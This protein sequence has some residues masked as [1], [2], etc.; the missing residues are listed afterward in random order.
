MSINILRPPYIK[1]KN[2]T[3]NPVVKYGIPDYAD[4]SLNPNVVGTPKWQTY[5]EEQLFYI[6][7]GYQTGGYFLP[8]RYYYYL[9]F[10][11]MSTITGIISPDMVDLHLELAYLIEWAK[12]NNKNVIVAKKRRA[13]I[14]EFT[15]K[16]VIDYGW[17][18]K[19]GYKAGIAAGKSTYA[20]ELMN[21]WEVSEALLPP[22]FSVK[23]LKKNSSE[24][25]AGYRAENSLGDSIEQGTKNQI[26][27]E[28]THQ[29]AELFKGLYL[30]DVIAEECG[31]FEKLEE[32]YSAT[33]ACL[34]DGSQQIG[35]MF[36]YGTGGNMDKGSKGFNEIWHNADKYD[37]VKFLIPAT[38]FHK[39]F[40]GGATQYGVINEKVPNL[41]KEF[42]P[43][44][45]I[46]VEDHEAAK[47]GILE[48][49]DREKRSG[50]IEKYNAH[51]QD[52]PFTEDEIFK[53]TIVNAFDED[54]L[55]EQQTQIL[56]QNKKY[57]RC[58]LDYVK[59]QTGEIK[60]PLQVIPRVDNTT[61]EDGAVILIHEDH[62]QKITTHDNMYVAGVDSYDQH[63]SKTS[64]SKGAMCV[65]IRRNTIKDS[66]QMA[67]IA[68]ICCRPPRKE[69][70][71]EMCL[72]L[73]IFYDLRESVLMDVRTPAIM[74]FFRERGCEKYLAFRPRKFEKEDSEQVNE[75]GISL[76][77]HSRPLMVG[78]MQSSILDYGKYIWFPELIKQ[79][80]NYDE[81]SIG[82]DND[83]GDAYGIA[84]MQDSASELRTR[85]KKETTNDKYS[86]DT[87]EQDSE[88]N[89]IPTTTHLKKNIVNDLF[90]IEKDLGGNRFGK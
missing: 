32:F 57:V 61:P 83:L 89:M 3:F 70:F 19:L 30:N 40:Y 13:G 82:S 15:H 71:Y 6:H 78:L 47:V 7:N 74:E 67:P 68:T 33:K 62:L 85:D 69:I 28:T 50:D 77:N 29:D 90:N 11:S 58:Q 34:K 27:V 87:W 63:L 41:L 84:L 81:V 48:E 8:G 86:L 9:N 79:L 65:L 25:I 73:A 52:Y 72:K 10:N 53:R 5:W 35:T 75:Y 37:F 24:I 14:S 42:K 39:P 43:Y 23:K 55:N 21:K 66:L 36:F 2:F 44:Q 20:E 64:K 18:F 12:V 1:G 45:I 51:L 22:E 4:S 26:Y 76:N 80:S 88:G 38:R 46:G 31:Q 17:R 56:S 16:A 54:I 49:R 60:H 59:D